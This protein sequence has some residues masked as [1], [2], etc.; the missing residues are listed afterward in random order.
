M[1]RGRTSS[2]KSFITCCP[3]FLAR[4]WLTLTLLVLTVVASYLLVFH[5]DFDYNFRN[6]QFKKETFQES[7]AV[8]ERQGKVYSGS[9]SPGAIYLAENLSALD[10]LIQVV[11][12]NK[13]AKGDETKLGRVRS[14]RDFTPTEEELEARLAFIEEIREQVQGRWVEKIEDE[15]KKHLIRDFKEWT[16]L[17]KGPAMSE[18]PQFF[19]N[20]YLAKDGSGQILL[21]IH[22][23]F[24]RKDGRN[25][26]AFTQEL[27]DLKLPQGVRGP[28]GETAVFA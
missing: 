22:P 17:T 27:Y 7:K 11:A 26:M 9:M 24:D 1:S 4:P 16:V 10:G 21:T 2:A 25:A 6:L 19:R 8:K 15:D 12:A 23:R 13:E 28:I 18:V 20:G 14:I 5:L 3:A